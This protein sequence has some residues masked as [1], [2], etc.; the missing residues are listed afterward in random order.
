MIIKMVKLGYKIF[1]VPITY[2]SREGNSKLSPIMDGIKIVLMLF[3]NLTW[4]QSSSRKH[5]F[6]KL[7]QNPN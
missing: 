4:K 2:D 7:L 6:K 3:K 1:S 5:Y